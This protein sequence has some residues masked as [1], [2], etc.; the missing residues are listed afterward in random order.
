[1]KSATDAPLIFVTGASRSGTTLMSR[2]LGNHSAILGMRELHYFGDLFEP[3]D[4]P[5]EF[6]PARTKA[7]ATSLFAR[8]RVDMWH[9]Q[10]TAE[11]EQQAAELLYACL[12]YTSDAADE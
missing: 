7:I 6:S 5:S 3:Q 11:D 4:Q 8:Q 12:L 10:I 1:M 2:L 9:A